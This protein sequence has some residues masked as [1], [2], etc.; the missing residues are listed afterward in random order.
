MIPPSARPQ[1]ARGGVSMVNDTSFLVRKSGKR[2]GSFYIDYQGLYKTVDLAK[3]TGLQ[4]TLIREIYLS[5]GAAY[6]DALDVFYF[7]D[8]GKANRGVAAIL[9]KIRYEKGR[10]V[11][12]TEAEIEYI[13]KALI[14]ESN[15]TIR[16]KNKV[17]DAIFDK[18][19]S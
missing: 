18:L 2:E 10:V 9:K 13:R 17:K 6:D 15:N 14:N 7:P 8:E 11:F 5:N 4:A 19:N 12:L 3:V 1:G 16:V